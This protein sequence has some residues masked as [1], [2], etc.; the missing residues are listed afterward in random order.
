MNTAVMTPSDRLL[1]RWPSSRSL[2]ASCSALAAASLLLGAQS[3]ANAQTDNFNSYSSV[4]DFQAAGWINAPLVPQ[5][6][7]TAFPTVAPGGNKG[8]Q[9]QANP[10]PGAAP[11]ANM[12]YKTNEYSDFYMAVDIVNW[13]AGS[14]DQASVLWARLTSASTGTVVPDL[15]P[16]D[17]QGVICNY[18]ASQDGQNAGDRKGGQLQINTVGAGFGTHTLV[19]AEITFEPGRSYRIIFS[20]YGSPGHYTAQAYDWNDLTTPLVTLECDDYASFNAV[21]HGACGLLAFSRDGTTGVT[22]ITFDNYYAGATNPNLATPPALSHPIPGT[23]AVA[24]RT[25]AGRWKNFWS[26]ASGISFTAKTYDATLINAAATKL[27]LNGTDVSSQLVMSANGATI[28]GSLPGSVLTSNKLYSAELVVTDVGGT[29]TSTN[30]FWFDTFSDAYLRTGTGV[31]TIEAE[32]Y[33]YSAGTNQP[34][35]IAVSGLDTNGVYVGGFGV[36]YFDPAASGYIVGTPEVDYHNHNAS[37]DAKWS[38]FRTLDAENT[39]N[40]GLIGYYGYTTNGAFN[41]L[42]TDPGSDNIRSQHAAVGLLEYV[43]G[44]NETGDWQNYTRN[45]AAGKYVAYLRYSSFGS[46]AADLDLVTSSP[47][48]PNQTTNKLGTFTIPNNIRWINY[49]YTPLLDNSGN[50]VVLDL[51]GVTTLRLYSAGTP[52]K[53]QRLAMLNY[54]LF[55]PAPAAPTVTVYSSATVNGTYTLESNAVTNPN[56][57]I[58]VPAVGSGRFYRL[59]SSSALTIKTITVSGGTVTLSY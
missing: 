3:S 56:G 14:L 10:Y 45:F 29:L 46:T 17:A 15:N 27:R 36:G 38:M 12:W 23:P 30:T 57:S 8:L 59:N 19:A 13:G 55:A 33:N 39:I 47:T 41:P 20:G 16:G 51:S 31:K 34:E 4:A 9:M 28:N 50:Q 25:P 7:A 58:S 26:P 42:E 5:L 35:P 53:D 48:Q 52:I 1:R 54:I 40:G 49:L 24:T 37:S 6:V 22:D 43:T 18:D 11:A 44:R 32:E 2:T 21:D